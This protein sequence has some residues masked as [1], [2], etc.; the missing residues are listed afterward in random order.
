MQLRITEN[1]RRA[2]YRFRM[3]REVR[4]T[5]AD[6]AAVGASGTGNTIN[7]SSGGIAFTSEKALKPGSLVELAISWPVL[8]GETCPIRLIVFG[9]LVRC[10]GLTAVCSIDKYEFR[11]QSRT[12]HAVAPPRSDTMLQRW[13]LGIRKENVRIMG[14]RA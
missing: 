6:E 11:T 3:E 12:L 9:R 10:D 8:L 1:E 2:K 14:A 5:L 13:A 4:Y 7:I